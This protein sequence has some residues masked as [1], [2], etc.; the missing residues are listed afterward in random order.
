MRP[1]PLT[2]P[3]AIALAVLLAATAPLA[4][5]TD[6]AGPDNGLLTVAHVINGPLGDSSFFDDAERGV[7]RFHD[8]GHNTRTVEAA[9][10]NPAQWKANAEQV[11]GQWDVVVVGSSQM[12][13]ILTTVAA[14]HPDQHY[15]IYDDVVTAANVASIVFKQNEGSFLAG[16]LAALVTTNP[17]LFPRATGS[18][19]I[20]LVGGMDVPVIQDFVIG[21]KAGVHA[22]DPS[23]PVQ[24]AFVGD[25]EDTQKA[26]D[27]ARSLY[28]DNNADVVYQVA[29]RAGSGVLKAAADVGRYAIGVDS[30]QNGVQEGF[31]LAS[32]LKNVGEGLYTALQ[33]AQAEQ[34]VWG[35]TTTYG[36]ADNGIALT[37]EGNGGIVP[38]E[39][40]DQVAEYARQVITHEISVPSA[41]N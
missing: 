4:A 11:T 36:L 6:D 31:I 35:Q 37:Y 2:R 24:T 15:I 23:I 33:S 18:R 3:S 5:C 7:Q 12:V 9:N 26:Y 30:N 28:L 41:L 19:D 13:D 17:D 29:G 27:L 21:F 25:F 34:L 38:K 39:I 8:G 32:M 40:Q 10:N 14:A 22:V 1:R 16:V 20:A